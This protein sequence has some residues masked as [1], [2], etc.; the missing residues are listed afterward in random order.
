MEYESL[1]VQLDDVVN[2]VWQQLM[3]QELHLHESVEVSFLNE[4]LI[5]IIILEYFVF[6]V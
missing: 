1:S 5:I 2:N 3:S 4:M 6:Y